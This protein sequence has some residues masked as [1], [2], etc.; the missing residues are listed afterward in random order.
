[1]IATIVAA[2]PIHGT[3]MTIATIEKLPN[4]V[5]ANCHVGTLS[6][7]AACGGSKNITST[8]K[9]IEAICYTVLSIMSIDKNF[10]V[11]IIRVGA[12]KCLI[13]IRVL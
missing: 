11:E 2:V 1:M 12:A 9:M 10:D 3:A 8:N 4:S 7:V 5:P 6:I 13:V